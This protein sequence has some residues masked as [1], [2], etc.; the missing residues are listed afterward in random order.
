MSCSTPNVPSTKRWSPT[1]RVAWAKSNHKME[2]Q[3]LNHRA[4]RD[5]PPKGLSSLLS[6]LSVFSVVQFLFC[7]SAAAALP[8]QNVSFTLHSAHV[9]KCSDP[10]TWTEHRISRS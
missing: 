3:E 5:R 10:N 1:S 6:M 9:G 8:K 4:H 7:A 2:M